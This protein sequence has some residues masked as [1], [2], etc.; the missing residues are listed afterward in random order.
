MGANVYAS[1]AWSA[2]F[3]ERVA[4]HERRRDRQHDRPDARH[5]RH[6][7]GVLMGGVLADRLGGKRDPRWRM[8]VPG[9]LCLIVVPPPMAMFLLAEFEAGVDRRP[10]VHQ[11]V[12]HRPPGADLRRRAVGRQGADARHRGWRWRS[13]APACSARRSGRWWSHA[14]RLADAQPGR[15]GHPLFDDDR[16]PRPPCWAA[17]SSC[18]A[19]PRS[20]RDARRAGEEG[21]APPIRKEAP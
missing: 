10:R 4:R 7:R 11:P 6:G 19:P 14:Q 1:G 9:I 20:R 21:D 5:P 12:H 13:S 15:G 2:T 17:S 18:S 16:D 8:L 3:L